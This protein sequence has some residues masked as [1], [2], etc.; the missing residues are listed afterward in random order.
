MKLFW[1]ILKGYAI[2]FVF[3]FITLAA[4]GFAFFE[5][6]NAIII[7]GIIAAITAGVIVYFIVRTKS[8]QILRANP[9]LRKPPP[10]GA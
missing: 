3:L 10:P 8:E 7:G 4:L 5:P 6:M 9:H 1:V 2:I